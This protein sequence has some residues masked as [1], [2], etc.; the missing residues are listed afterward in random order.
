MKSSNHVGVIFFD[1]RKL[2]ENIF[3][4]GDKPQV[5]NILLCGDKPQVENIFP[6]GD[7]PQVENI[8]RGSDN[9]SDYI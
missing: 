9:D 1:F 7:K 8:E 3:L 6:C 2:Y 5:E 4:C